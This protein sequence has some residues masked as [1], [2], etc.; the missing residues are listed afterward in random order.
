MLGI[1]GG[2]GP[3]A[4]ADFLMKLALETPANSDQ[5]HFPTIVYSDPSTPDRSDAILGR[6]DS[7]YLRLLAGVNFLASNGAKAISIPCNTAHFWYEELSGAIE[8]PIIHIVDSVGRRIVRE[9]PELKRI[10]I[11]ST[12][13]TA[14]ARLYH[15]LKYYGYQIYDFF[16]LGDQRAVVEAIRNVKAGN[17]NEG[18]E[19]LVQ[20][21]NS[22][23]DMGAEGVV[24][25]CTDISA[26]MGTESVDGVM[27]PTWDSAVSLAKAS[28]DFMVG[29]GHES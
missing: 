16:E 19:A 22:L 17:V 15:K 21:A 3:L 2:M 12:E 8:V 9:R 11:L 25:G 4:T 14:H 7:P 20:A 28:V 5:E 6:A 27:A 10:G 1:L 29:I 18:R 13:G 26:A 24:F 23:V